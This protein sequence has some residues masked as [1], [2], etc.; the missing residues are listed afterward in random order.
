MP[1]TPCPQPTTFAAL[2]SGLPDV[3]VLHR[4][5]PS[6]WCPTCAVFVELRSKRGIATKAQSRFALKWCRPARSGG[7]H[8]AR[9]RH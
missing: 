5:K 6:P 8:A 9:V 2:R 3:L 1:H 7:W 4:R